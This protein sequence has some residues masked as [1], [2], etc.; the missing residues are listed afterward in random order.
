M[1][2]SSA[3]TQFILRLLARQVQGASPLSQ[4]AAIAGLAKGKKPSRMARMLDKRGAGREGRSRPDFYDGSDYP[5]GYKG[6]DPGDIDS[7]RELQRIIE[8]LGLEPS[9]IKGAGRAARG[10]FQGNPFRAKYRGDHMAMSDDS[11][12]LSQALNTIPDEIDVSSL[13]RLIR[14]GA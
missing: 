9:R 4:R 14:E 6:P 7:L 2:L 10:R 1:A 12:G 8:G 5:F 11:F 3:A 13:I